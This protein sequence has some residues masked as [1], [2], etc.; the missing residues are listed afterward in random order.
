MKKMN[1][2]LV[3]NIIIYEVCEFEIENKYIIKLSLFSEYKSWKF[4]LLRNLRTV[5]L[6]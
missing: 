4:L 6:F 3:D 5:F 2:L 1:F